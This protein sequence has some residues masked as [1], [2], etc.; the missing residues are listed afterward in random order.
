MVVHA[1]NPSTREAEA[2]GFLSSRTARSIQ[3]NPVSE[4]RRK[5]QTE[6]GLAV[7]GILALSRWRPEGQKFKVTLG[8]MRPCCKTKL[9]RKFR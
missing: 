4:K 7:P 2:A 1:F 5:N 8:Y 6:L 9:L 3:R